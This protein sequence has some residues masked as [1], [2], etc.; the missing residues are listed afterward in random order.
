MQDKIKFILIVILTIT[1]IA[2]FIPWAL[3]VFKNGRS[4]EAMSLS[5][6]AIIIA[7][8]AFIFLKMNYREIKKGF[9]LQDERSKRITL[10]SA[11]YAF[12][13]GIY[14]LLVIMYYNDITPA[15]LTVDQALS[16]GILGM[17]IIFALS[18]LYLNKKG[19]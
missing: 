12:Y 18:Y 15:K 5:L 1:F 13:I 8:F 6:I 17:S 3:M 10:N 11:A 4:V 19:E 7:V 2:G 16:A 9:P 14:W